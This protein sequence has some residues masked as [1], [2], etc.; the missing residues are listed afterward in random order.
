MTSPGPTGA[1]AATDRLRRENTALV[2]R[3]LR[4]NGSASRAAIAQRTGLAK[5]TVSAIV[6]ELS[7]AGAVLESPAE[8]DVAPTGRSGRP[9]RPVRLHGRDTV[10]LGL[11]VN[12]GYLAATA[13][14][15]SGRVVLSSQVPLESDRAGLDG[16]LALAEDSLARLTA[17]GHR[18]LG[19]TLAV[20]GQVEL[21]TGR[22]IE[23]PNLHWHDRDVAADL[24]H[25]LGELTVR[26]DNDANC[27]A[28]G[29]AAFGAGR[30]CSDLLYLTGTVGVGAGVVVAGELRR[31][32]H[33]LAGEVGHAPL[34]AAG[35]PCACGRTGCWETAVG[36]LALLRETGTSFAELG[37]HD[38]VTVASRIAE[39]CPDDEPVRAGV[40]RF[41]RSLATGLAVLA[42]TLDPEVIVLGGSFVPLGD[43]L[44]PVVDEQVAAV[45]S[46]RVALSTLG[47]HAASTGA[48]A[49]VLGEVYAGTL[50][51]A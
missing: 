27:A 12:V 26:V 34:G 2:L 1:P 39:R 42:A 14:D 20:P 11:E 21:D 32:A 22:V 51:L 35:A 7:S 25:A 13:L 16:V 31:G 40:L 44:L 46:S 9:G 43:W 41:G 47:L 3:S 33:G 10:G 49:A 24:D 23:A 48:A 30:G 45:S 36:L 28:A 50:A 37:S 6:A 15:L 19:L 4:D 17:D 38:P 5:A 29:E 8:P 18:V